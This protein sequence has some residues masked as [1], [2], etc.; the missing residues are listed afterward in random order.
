MCRAWLTGVVASLLATAPAGAG[1]LRGRV[2]VVEKD[3][4]PAKDIADAVVWV[5]GPKGKVASA[6]TVVVMRGKAFVPRV[7]VVG[8][9]GTVAFPNQDPIFHNAFSVSGENRFDLDLY[10]KPK[11]ASWTFKY[12]GLVRVFCNIHPQMSAFVLVRDNP[13]WARPAADGSFEIPDVPAGTWV[14]KAWHE[15]AGE[16]AEPL[17][18]PET[19]AVATTLKLDASG[20]KRAPHKNKYGKDYA[21]GEKY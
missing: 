3:Q 11:S 13:F 16:V 20:Y 7:A 1:T 19:G 8:V 5:E 6:E 12:P 15:R 17:R 18:V 10:K 14:V 21:V 4:R 9:G 2:E